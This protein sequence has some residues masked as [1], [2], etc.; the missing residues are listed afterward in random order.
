MT[1][2]LER[3]GLAPNELAF[4]FVTDSGI[5]AR[6]LAN[7]LSRA[8]TVA[9]RHGA[10]LRVVGVKDGS[11]SVTL[12]VIAKNAAKEF[13]D[14]PIDAALKVTTLVGAVAAGI[15]YMMTPSKAG[16]TPIAKAGAEIV[17]KQNVTQIMLVTHGQSVLVMDEARAIELREIVQRDELPK[18]VAP[19]ATRAAIMHREVADMIADARAGTLVGEIIL[20]DDQLHFR[21][22]G[23]HFLVPVDPLKSEGF[24]DLHPG[25]RFMITGDIVDV[26]G[27][28]DRLIVY[29]AVEK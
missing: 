13:V 5:E 19:D 2:N 12:R 16:E 24:H 8:G 1:G 7:F 20:A 23:Y 27:R 22:K 4:Y 3:L 25:G 17:I 14:K 9:N 21:P 10:E 18:L 11:V 6:T 26:G 15:I 28:P 29:G